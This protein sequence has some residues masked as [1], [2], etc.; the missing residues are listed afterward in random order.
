[1]GPQSPSG[2]SCRAGH[3]KD[4]EV[5]PLRF[6]PQKILCPTDMSDLSAVAVHTGLAWR[7]SFTQGLRP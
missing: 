2:G 6:P 3:R 1:V 4:G 5:I 7:G